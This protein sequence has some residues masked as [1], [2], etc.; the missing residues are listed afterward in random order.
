MTCEVP[1]GPTMLCTCTYTIH[2]LHKQ[3]AVLL[4]D[5]HIPET[6]EQYCSNNLCPNYAKNLLPRYFL[7]W[8]ERV[9]D[10]FLSWRQMGSFVQLITFLLDFD[11]EFSSQHKKKYMSFRKVHKSNTEFS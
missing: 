2:S 3:L 9:Y 7:R 1:L 4:S 8:G 11:T 10:I 6:L 5:C